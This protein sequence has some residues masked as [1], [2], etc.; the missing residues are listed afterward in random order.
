MS[1]VHDHPLSGCRPEPLGSYLKALGMLRIVGEQADPQAAGRWAGEAF[2]LATRLDVG[3]LCDFLLDDYV[4][5]PLVSPWNGG[6][7]FAKGDQKAR[8]EIA[9]IEGNDLPRLQ[10]Y[11]DTLHAARRLVAEAEQE[12][13]TAKDDKERF[14]QRCRARLPDEAVAWLDAAVVLTGSG[15]SFPTLLGTG[16]NLGRLDLSANFMTRL[17]DVLRLRSGRNAPSRDNSLAWLAA[18]LFRQP[19]PGVKASIGQ[20]D[21]VGASGPTS[22]AFGAAD[23]LIN[24]WDAV[25]LLEGAL[26]FASAAARRLGLATGGSA[27][28]PFTVGSTSVG[29][30]SGAAGENAKG[31]V[32]APLWSRPASLPELARLIGEGRSTWRRHQARNG[33]DFARAAASLGVDRGIQAFAR[34]AVVE[35]HGQSPLAVPAG[36]FTVSQRPQVP[37]LGQLDGWL[38]RIRR[39]GELPAGAA[40]ALRRVHAK[41]FDVAAHGGAEPLQRV[42][43]ELATL[44][45]AVGRSGSLR[46]RVPPVFG[47]QAADWL[48]LLVGDDASDELRI[49]AA[50]ASQRDRN[51]ACLRFLLRPVR[52]TPGGQAGGRL[53]FTGTAPT[54][55]GLGQRPLTEVLAGAMIVRARGAEST[56]AENGGGTA[57]ARQ[58][59]QVQAGAPDQRKQ[60]RQ[61][62]AEDQV[63]VTVAYD[64]ALPA[65]AQAVAAL[66]RGSVD[67]AL[68]AR[69]LAGMLMLSWTS[70]RSPASPGGRAR[71]VIHPT[72]LGSPG[73]APLAHLASPAFAVIAPFFQSRPVDPGGGREP[74]SPLVQLS[75]PSQ[76][77]AGRVRH[78]LAEADRRLRMAGL[79]PAVR[80]AMPGTPR[81]GTRLAAAL[82]VPLFRADADHLLR[83]VAPPPLTDATEA[84]RPDPVNAS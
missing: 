6:S 81:D 13:W 69:L 28:M 48:P 56:A 4:P 62:R 67:E 74:L 25:L 39:S 71:S 38:D 11:R 8:A 55:P 76:L 22:S 5:T 33:L 60:A 9:L 64:F 18:A 21:P 50:L 36:R 70:G 63:G 80:P 65:A 10:P 61:G 46:E 37:V 40:A 41:M 52:P 30:A 73:G 66:L 68:L 3:A 24:P 2:V 57:S 44:E 49:A 15:L 78:V 17:A 1:S 35:R 82:L 47:L 45:A 27:A 7:G 43:V 84:D 20:F 79:P 42:L 34:H 83:Q 29:Y 26:L 77:R 51:G 53:V 31:E 54:V 23:S 32:W 75:W 72:L 58:A 16:G 14:V 59:T 19:V 12:G